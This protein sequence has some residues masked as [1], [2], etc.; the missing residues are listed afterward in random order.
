MTDAT[1]VNPAALVI[2]MVA[3]S[4]RATTALDLAKALDIYGLVR[5]RASEAANLAIVLVRRGLVVR[6]AGGGWLPTGKGWIEAVDEAK[7]K[8]RRT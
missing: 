2:L 5:T 8:S 3:G 7:S 4:K 6:A 1:N